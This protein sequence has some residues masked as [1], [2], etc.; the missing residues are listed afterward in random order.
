MLPDQISPRGPSCAAI[1]VP[2]RSPCH[3]GEGNC[4]KDEA[5]ARPSLNSE[6][7]SVIYE[8]K[9]QEICTCKVYAVPSMKKSYP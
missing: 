6:M 1:R 5:G 8:M 2:W 3:L 9:L 4:L 7:C